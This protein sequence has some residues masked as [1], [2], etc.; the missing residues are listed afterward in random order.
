MNIIECIRFA[1]KRTRRA[2]TRRNMQHIPRVGLT[3]VPTPPPSPPPYSGVNRKRLA[4]WHVSDLAL[5]A[6]RTVVAHD[7]ETFARAR[8]LELCCMYTYMH[9]YVHCADTTHVHKHAIH[10]AVFWCGSFYFVWR[11][12]TRCTAPTPTQTTCQATVVAT[13]LVLGFE[14]GFFGASGWGGEGGI[15]FRLLADARRTH[16]SS[17]TIRRLLRRYSAILWM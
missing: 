8:I 10:G 9:V 4:N 11:T 13:K 16:T 15:H 17:R 5:C 14:A 6:K 12:N 7:I 2:H 3:P 1:F